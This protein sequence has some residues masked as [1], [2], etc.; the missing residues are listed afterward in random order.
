M[1]KIYLVD[2]T[3]ALALK[4]D[5]R[6]GIKDPMLMNM[7]VRAKLIRRSVTGK[8]DWWKQVLDSKYME[9]PRKRS[10]D[11]PLN[12]PVGSPIWKLL[13]ASQTIMQSQ[14]T[15]IPGNRKKIQLWTDSLKG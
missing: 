10:F 6:L 11:K 13:Q 2:W 9:G 1:K 4:I 5:G 7:A 8:Y 3:T 15:W 12:N 14:L